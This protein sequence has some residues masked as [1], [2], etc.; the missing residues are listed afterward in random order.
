MPD[1]KAAAIVLAA[2][3]G[4]R[5]KSNLP[6]VMHRIGGRTLIG[7]VLGCLAPLHLSRIV[8]IIAPGMDS[9]EKEV[10]PHGVAFQSE[11]LGTGHAVGCARDALKDFSGDV[12]V[13]YGDT[14]FVATATLKR[15]F[16][17]RKAPDDPA[18]VVLGMR[19]ADPSGY[20]RLVLGA[21]GTLDRIVEHK[22]ANE[23]ERAIGLANSGVMVM[24][25]TVAW[26]LIDKLNNRN[27]KG[28][29]YLTDTVAHARKD[30]RRT[31]SCSAST[32]APSW[33]RPKRCSRRGGVSP[34]WRTAQ[35]SPILPACSSPPTPRSAA[36]W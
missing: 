32:A 13:V 26:S 30:G 6:K 18:I 16:E 1:L 14:P 17:R 4:T 5:M 22:D 19:P 15:M 8:T 10:A 27:A 25:G 35:P 28:E 12:L 21:D 20:G 23:A 2:G 24:D 33:R 36:T 11:Q 9:V 7:H 34:R 3:K 29:F 31:R